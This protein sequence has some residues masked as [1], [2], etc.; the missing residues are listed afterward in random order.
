MPMARSKGGIILPFAWKGDFPDKSVNEAAQDLGLAPKGIGRRSYHCNR[1]Q[2]DLTS[3]IKDG[4]Q[5]PLVCED[6]VAELQA[7]VEAQNAEGVPI[8][9]RGPGFDIVKGGVAPPRA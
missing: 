2:R 7:Q 3:Y 1:C 6:C 5:P 8:G 4:K 9:N